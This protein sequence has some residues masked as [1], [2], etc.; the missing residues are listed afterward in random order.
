MGQGAGVCDREFHRV[1][2]IFLTVA[3]SSYFV[4]P[5][6]DNCPFQQRGKADQVLAFHFSGSRASEEVVRGL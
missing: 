6:S 3:F 5:V 2:L 4:V 1:S